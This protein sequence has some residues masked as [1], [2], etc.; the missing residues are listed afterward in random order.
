MEKQNQ[1]KVNQPLT[2]DKHLNNLYLSVIE[3]NKDLVI[4]D[5][6]YGI[7]NIATI[8]VYIICI[9]KALFSFVSIKSNKTSW[10]GLSF[11]FKPISF[12]KN[13]KSAVIGVITI[14][15][16]IPIAIEEIKDLSINELKNLVELILI[17]L[18]RVELDSQ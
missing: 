16:I 11:L 4:M 14:I 18:R 17:G 5:G 9:A 12:Y 7:S 15:K 10:I 8:I 6:L 1:K 13:I 2:R 3:D